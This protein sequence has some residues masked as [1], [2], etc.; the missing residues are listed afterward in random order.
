MNPDRKARQIKA[1]ASK[2]C[3]RALA[4]SGAQINVMDLGKLARV[5]EDALTSGRSDDGTR[6][7]V[8]HWI[9]ANRANP[10]PSCCALARRMGGSKCPVCLRP[11]DRSLRVEPALGVAS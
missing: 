10:E 6:A 4:E 2:I 7:A 3:S 9:E 8:D 1:R 11:C 5:A